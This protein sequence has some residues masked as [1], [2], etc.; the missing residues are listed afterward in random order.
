MAAGDEYR[1]KAA[2]FLA[3][4]QS[5]ADPKRFME[6]AKLAGAYQR[7]AD[8]AERNTH[9]DLAYESQPPP[10]LARDEPPAG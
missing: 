1:A 3:K 6:L 8:Q 5:E 7:L 10:A 2:E 4:A 9:I